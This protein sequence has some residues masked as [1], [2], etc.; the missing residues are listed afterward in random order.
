MRASFGVFGNSGYGNYCTVK[1]KIFKMKFRKH[2]NNKGN[3]QIKSGSSERRF[4]RFA[5]RLGLGKVFK[6]D[7]I[8][9]G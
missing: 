5:K 1:Q 6:R 9:N 4:Y 3:K 2:H 7:K 8:H